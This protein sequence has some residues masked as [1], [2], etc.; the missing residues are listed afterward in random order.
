MNARHVGGRGEKAAD[1][2]ARDEHGQTT[3][4]R[5]R[6]LRR[7]AVTRHRSPSP[8]EADPQEAT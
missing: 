4:L 3:P 6:R 7:T 5:R 8:F 2:I 1:V